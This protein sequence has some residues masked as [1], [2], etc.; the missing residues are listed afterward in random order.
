MSAAHHRA[1]FLCPNERRGGGSVST[2][3]HDR[4][5]DWYFMHRSGAT[6]PEIAASAGVGT[7]TVERGLAWCRRARVGERETTAEL[8]KRIADCKRDIAALESDLRRV[9]RALRTLYPGDKGYSALTNS[10]IG[11]RREL[12]EARRYLAE[13]EGL[14]RNVLAIEPGDN[15]D[16][17]ITITH[18]KPDGHQSPAQ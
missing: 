16:L 12:R 15:T 1:A 8:E 7:A 18:V 17:R 11:F 6:I 14:I 3:T 9:K 4:Y 5:I 13:L 2:S 10:I